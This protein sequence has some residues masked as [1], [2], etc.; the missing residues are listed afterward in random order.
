[1]FNVA[2]LGFYCAQRFNVVSFPRRRK[3]SFP[4]WRVGYYFSEHVSFR[5]GNTRVISDQLMESNCQEP[6]L[7][8]LSIERPGLL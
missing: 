5:V 7:E 1:M 8:L 4:V 6:T 2:Q 3:L